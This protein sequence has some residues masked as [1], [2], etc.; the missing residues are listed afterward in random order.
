MS[1]ISYNSP[2]P[3]ATTTQKRYSLQCYSCLNKTLKLYT[4][5]TKFYYNLLSAYLTVKGLKK[6]VAKYRKSSMKCN[7]QICNSFQLPNVFVY[8]SKS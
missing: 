4:Q 8:S 2:S 5:V 6:N 1:Y 3:Q 7:I